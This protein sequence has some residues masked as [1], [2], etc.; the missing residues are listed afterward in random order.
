[1]RVAVVALIGSS[2]HSA[3]SSVISMAQAVF[4][5][6]LYINL[7][8]LYRKKCAWMNVWN[9]LIVKFNIVRFVL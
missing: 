3:L 1:M 8:K 7:W 4:E 2:D 6:V 9:A 5:H